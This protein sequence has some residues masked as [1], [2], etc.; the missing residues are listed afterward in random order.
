MILRYLILHYILSP[1]IG[2]VD[3]NNPPKIV[4]IIRALYRPKAV[5][6]NQQHAVAL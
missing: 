1:D 5:K 6:S 3:F 4:C 2:G